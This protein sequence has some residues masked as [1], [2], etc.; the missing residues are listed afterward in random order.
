[1]LR[2]RLRRVG[3]KKKPSYRIVVADQ[4]ASRN[5]AFVDQI[6]HYDPMINPPA[7]TIDEEK[8][9][10]WLR[11]GAQPSES[12]AQILKKTGV[13]EKVKQA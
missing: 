10:K 5:G 3:A 1:M 4:H 12:V 2:I 7:V 13:L 11:T 9:L 6:G 8:T